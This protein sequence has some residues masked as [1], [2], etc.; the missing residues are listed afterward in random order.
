[1]PRT[2]LKLKKTLGC[3]YFRYRYK[4]SKGNTGSESRVDAP[5]DG[6]LK[7]RWAREGPGERQTWEAALRS[8]F[9]PEQ[10]PAESV[11]SGDER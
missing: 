5:V 8:L 2:K 10:A 11:E 1:M 3:F 4:N 7:G 9:G 6:V